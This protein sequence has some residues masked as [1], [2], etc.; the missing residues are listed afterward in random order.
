M[1][2]CARTCVCV[3]VHV[4]ACVSVCACVCICCCF[5]NLLISKIDYML[6]LLLVHLIDLPQS[7]F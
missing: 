4:C 1:C 3:C 7:D 2:A 5:T 6:I